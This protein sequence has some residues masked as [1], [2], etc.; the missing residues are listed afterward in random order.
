MECAHITSQTHIIP[1]NPEEER[2]AIEISSLPLRQL[3]GETLLHHRQ[4]MYQPFLVSRLSETLGTSTTFH[5]PHFHETTSHYHDGHSTR[6]QPLRYHDEYKPTANVNEMRHFLIATEEEESLR[7]ILLLSQQIKK[8]KDIPQVMIHYRGQREEAIDF[9][10]VIVRLVEKGKEDCFTLTKL[11][12]ILR[13]IP[14]RKAIVGSV[15]GRLQKQAI[16]FIVQ[17]SKASFLRENQ[18]LDFLKARETVVSSLH[19]SLGPIRDVNGGLFYQQF[20][21]IEELRPLLSEE[22]LPEIHIVENL[23]HSLTPCIAK[24]MVCKEHLLILLRHF[25][26][27]RNTMCSMMNTFISEKHPSAAFVSFTCSKGHPPEE[28]LLLKS[29]LHLSDHCLTTCQTPFFD[30]LFGFAICFSEDDDIQ[31]RFIASAQRYVHDTRD[32]T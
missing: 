28:L 17:C 21:L 30:H 11:P 24:I 29:Y 14:T 2:T 6:Q 7:T 12:A 9:S 16:S 27:L 10:V 19:A 3:V 22:E 31:S 32:D 23:F 26:T 13:L 18:S 4:A 5:R 25:R 8:L 1:L 15:R 20:R